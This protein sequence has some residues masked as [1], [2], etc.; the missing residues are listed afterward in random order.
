MSG[1]ALGY[2][3]GHAL[4]LCLGLGHG[5]Q[6]AL[7]HALRLCLGLGHGLQHALGHALRLCFGLGHGLQHA[8]GHA[9]RLC[10]GLGHGLQHALRHALRLC[11]VLGH[12]L[13][14]ALRRALRLCLGLGLVLGLSGGLG[15]V[16]A[17]H[18]VTDLALT[19]TA[20]EDQRLTIAGSGFDDGHSPA[21]TLVYEWARS[22][23]GDGDDFVVIAD[24]TERRYQLIQADVGRRVRGSVLYTNTDGTANSRVAG[25]SAPVA[26]VNDPTTGLPVITGDHIQGETLTADTSAIMDEDGLGTFTYRWLRNGQL[27]PVST[28][29]TYTL[30]QADVGAIMF[31]DVF[32]TDAQGTIQQTSLFSSFPRI[33]NIN[34]LPTGLA[35]SG[36]LLVGQTLRADT[37]A[38]VDIDGL[39]AESEFSYQWRADGADIA[40]A[41]EPEYLL[42][43][44]NIGAQ[45]SLNLQYRDA[46]E[47]D[48]SITSPAR[49]PVRGAGDNAAPTSGGLTVT[50][51]EDTDY[52]FAVAD[53]PF[54]DG[55]DDDSLQ[56]VRIDSL[57][58]PAS[59]GALT[60]NGA[61]LSAGQ[62]I[63][64]GAIAN[65]V[66]TPALNASGSV[67]FTYSVS[68]GVVFSTPSATATVTVTPVNDAPS[69]SGLAVTTDEDTPR[70]FGAADF[71]F[72]DGD[73]GDNLQAVRIDSLPTPASLGALTLNGAALSAGQEIAVGNIGTLVFTPALNASGD[74]SFTYSV[75]DGDEF[76]ATANAAITIAAVNDPPT[77][78]G[79]PQTRVSAGGTYNFTPGG[80]DVDDGDTLEYAISTLPEWADFDT[81][82]GA[83]TNK[84]NRPNSGDIRNYEDIVI[85]VTDGIIATPVTLPA[86]DIE[87]TAPN[88]PPTSIGSTVT[89]A[90]DSPYTFREADFP[91][92]DA[93][94]GDSLQAVRIVTLP[95]STSGNLALNGT[96]VIVGQVIAVGDIGTLMFTPVTNF[97]GTTTFLYSVSDGE[98]FS[99]ANRRVLVVVT[100]VNDPPDGEVMI[101]GTLRVG[102]TL[103][104]D[105]S[106]ISDADGPDSLEFTYQW[107]TH[108]GGTDTAISGADSATYTLST[109]DLGDQITVTVRYTDADTASQSLTSAPT[110]AV[111]ADLSGTTT[112][113]SV[114]P[115]GNP[116]VIFSDLSVS[117]RPD[118][119]RIRVL[120]PTALD[121]GDTTGLTADANTDEYSIFTR[122]GAE[123][124]A[125]PH[126]LF[127]AIAS[128]DAFTPARWHGL[129]RH[130]TFA[131]PAATGGRQIQLI[132]EVS[133]DS[134]S[135]YSS[136]TLTRTL[137]ISANNAPTSSGLMATLDEDDSHTFAAEQFGFA[138]T[139]SGDSLQAVRIDSLPA[140][141]NG[142]LAL[143]G[144]A[145]IVGQEIGVA[146]IPTLV[147]TPVANANGE[148][149]FTFSV[150]DGDD[151]ST[152]PATATL[153]VTPVDDAPTTSG[154]TATLDEDDSH[155]FAADQFGFDDA[156]SGDSLQQV[157]IDTLPAA[158]SGS[159]AL[160]GTPVTVPQEIG[161]AAIPTLVYTPVANVNGEATFTFSVSDGTAFSATATATLTVTPVNDAPTTSGLMANVTED[162]PHAFAAG[163]FNFVDADG[164]ALHSL[165]IDTLPA[166]GSLALS[167]TAVDA[168]DVIAAADIPNL[169]Y[170]PATNATGTVTFTYSLSDNTAFSAPP[171]TATLTI[172]AD[173]DAPTTTGLMVNVTEDTPHAFAAGQFNF[174]DADGDALH[175]L[176]IDTLPATGSLALS[177]TAVDA[178]DVIAAADIPNLVYTPATNATGT[179]TF[180]YSLSDNTAFSAPPATATLTITADNDAP[181]TTG[182]M[183]NV[184][185][186]TPHAFAAGQFNFVDA[187]GDALHSL[188]IDTLPATG[189]LAL[190]GTAVDAMDVIAAADIPNL[191]YTPATN[192]TGTVTFTYS[193]SDNTAFSAPP[194]TATLTITADNDAPTTTGLM[195]NVTEDTPHAFAAGQFNFVDA[196]GD[197]LHSLRIDT[198]P[199][200]GSLALSG[201]A[202]DAMDVIAAA[203]IPNLVYTP[204]TNATG[205]VTFTYS[206]SDNTAFSAPPAT[207]TLTITADN[208]APTTTGLMVNVTED[209]PH[210]FAA[211]QFNFVDA[212]GDALHSLRIDTL[213]ATGSLALSGTA[214]DAM[215]V[216]AAADIPNLVYTPATNATGTVTFTYSLSDNTAFSAPPATAT[217]TI[218][219]DNDAPTTTGLMV[220][221]TED[222]PHAFAAGQFNFV[223]ADG[224][225]LHSLRI[226]TLPATGSLA[227][228][229][230]AVDAMDVI[231]AAD[232]PNLVYTPATNATGT[233]TFT[234][235]LSDNT[236]F[237]APPATATLTI[238]A[239]N[240]APTTTGLMV[241]VTEDT[242]HAFAAGQFNFVDADGDALHSLRIDT[243]PAT[244]S[245]ALSGTAVD[246]MDVIA[247][248]DIPNLVY[249]PATNA[250]GTVTFT[251]SL[252]DNT[253]FS[254]PP[255]TATLTITADNDAPTTTGLMVNVTEDTPHAFA[256]GQFNFVDADGD[257][258]HSLRIDTLPATGSLALSGTAVD[259]M[260]VIAAADIP[261]LVYTPATN[262][263][264]TV[265]FT[266]SL[267]DNT[268][269]S[270]PP[271]TAT[272]TITEASVPAP[273]PGP[274]PGPSAPPPEVPDA[275]EAEAQG[276]EPASTN[277]AG[278]AITLPASEEVD[279]S[280]AS[281]A[282]FTVTSTL[283]G[284]TTDHDVTAIRAGSII[285]DVTPPIPAGAD[286]EVSY[287]PALGSITSTATGEELA[288]FM[289]L[290]VANTVPAQVAPVAN[291]GEPQTVA[292]GATVTLNGSAT[293]PD[294]DAADLSYAWTQTSGQQ[295]TLSGADSPS[296]SFTAPTGLS[297]DAVLVFSL[298]VSDGSLSAS[299]SVNVTVTNVNDAP[300][301]D[302]GENQSVDEGA[303]VT[304]SGSGTDP[305]TG[306]SLSYA[307]TQTS[308]QDVTLSGADSP[309]ASFTAPT[310]LGVDAVLGF[311]LTVS[312]GRLSASAS[313]TVTVTAA[314]KAPSADAGA[315][316]SVDEG[317]A[318]TLSGSGT[319]PDP[320]DT[321]SLS[322]AWIQ[323]GGPTVSLSRANSASPSFTAPNALD[324]DTVLTFRLTVTDPRGASGSDSVQVTVET[325]VAARQQALELNLA[326]FGRSV[327]AS[328]V[329]AIGERLKPASA[330]PQ[331]STVSGLSLAACLSSI[332]NLISADTV[333][334]NSDS[335]ADSKTTADNTTDSA[336]STV[337]TNTAS[338]N[339]VSANTAT[340]HTA[341]LGD[342]GSSGDLGSTGNLGDSM[343]GLNRASTDRQSYNP[344]GSACQL[345]DREQLA[346]SAF[347]IPLGLNQNLN[348]NLNENNS[349]AEPSAQWSLWGRGD[350]SHFEGSPQSDFD[351]DGEV[352]SGYLGLDYRL[353]T[354]A[355]VGVAL[356]HSS[357]ETDYRSGE[358]DGELETDLSSVYP[359]GYW[360]PRD[361]L[362]LWGL[363]GIG[364]GDATLSHGATTFET[365]LDMRLGALGLRQALHS[366]GEFELAL[367]ADAFIVELESEDVPGLPEV[368]AQARR[369]RLLLEASRHWQVQPE[370]SLS[371][372]LELGVRVDGGDAEEG[373]GA[374]VGVGLEYANGR[375][376][377]TALRAHGL[378]AHKESDFEAWGASLTVQLDPG[379]SGQG[380][381]L[382]LTPVWGQDSGGGAQALWESERAL[383]DSGLA[384]R[385]T[386][387]LELNLSY[388]LVQSD[389]LT[390]L[391]PFAQ[392]DMADGIARRLRLG[393]QLERPDG[394]ELEVFAGR[395]ASEQ[396]APEH[397][398]GLSGRLH[399]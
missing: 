138:D 300:S 22:S 260:D 362:G 128:G 118:V 159:L 254:A 5:L 359:Y 86:F 388:G 371:T 51:D 358:T 156:D 394:L 325:N 285:L 10:L 280:N 318:V 125:A 237:S 365:D 389:R 283:N 246:A 250:T 234:Y 24:A 28:E 244:G 279:V 26:N 216:I 289:S 79:S 91:F 361:G 137:T 238:T 170:T 356:S 273:G 225:A 126:N 239:D 193:L 284:V 40:N 61:A 142:S 347:V 256:A 286:I 390:R 64:S 367:K 387:R 50:T 298:T 290:S 218:T 383:Q 75:S 392:L 188:R 370:A 148:A 111:S 81:A 112:P 62:V 213:P 183:V 113:L 94:A 316:Q 375:G 287:R 233:V 377:S 396:R 151:F 90:E 42:T 311:S 66:F 160:N 210:A 197:A 116:V 206:L 380:L 310:E 257:A 130:V 143:D 393:M 312:D 391:R 117:G 99:V 309:S 265:T 56:A 144:T 45:I 266:Y 381:A 103:T 198:L 227:L 43:A 308:G 271:A 84:T 49:G 65:L 187:D 350:F 352:V 48:E 378:L 93:D 364:Q 119:F 292:E 268:A 332:T 134:G 63:A 360:S 139:D 92:N 276:L 179:V 2:A 80:G 231:A 363:L 327:A 71:P 314:N 321:E 77:I 202:V 315:D 199:A 261:N 11:F 240:D 219:A 7:H 46:F 162:T 25:I 150:S 73:T 33:T 376:L 291:A 340:V 262:A 341:G 203:D 157:R 293:D 385:P 97:N 83:L 161:V 399:F 214:V 141:G 168:M 34:D 172:T 274:A 242:P 269:F 12:G 54:D 217:L 140:A 100:A 68:D 372:S 129:L 181:T 36:G 35:I 243:L 221:V 384:Q 357:G 373:E 167:G 72:S 208:D 37:S 331:T 6:H 98:D 189:S 1:R 166:T 303:A 154:L 294:S 39:P 8:L 114:T 398:L 345:P 30:T 53:F 58:T 326:A 121:D 342:L 288:S 324:T 82:T 89:T 135:S 211:G 235:S 282:D 304:L 194:A 252:S 95:A 249:T 145:V 76:S 88:N 21:G 105:T 60:L 236:A 78:S 146:A 3:L 354:G 328:A 47:A 102:A 295:V 355:L 32:H 301:A 335:T 317:A 255:A 263:T 18:L 319:D 9:L 115:G 397:L 101:S 106:G 14:H 223:D 334:A 132:A 204:A 17:D 153:T 229:G 368:T 226:D 382:T 395:N 155:T 212:D 270:A 96:A 184:T 343:G 296:P 346:R 215:D 369:A 67:I 267:S 307:W 38:L 136:Q 230:T 123:A 165:R 110:A 379:V 205:T 275:D 23:D 15:A 330:G 264:G 174:V 277:P 297:A 127:T 158:G 259:A 348:Q 232:I 337:S 164:D 201:T 192:A 222:T 163:Q 333:T 74:V 180:T 120:N 109:G 152:T 178:M 329:D 344:V 19:G 85:S 272:L 69:S 245:L 220:N 41:T 185:E 302:A 305:D 336:D 13:Q 241:N 173:N 320:G 366:T 247:A 278:T 176:R 251:Y 182:L 209:T 299:D 27:P 313:V 107:N 122:T 171:A 258:L 323:T 224:D 131:A 87:V 31:L 44:A 20:R 191:V 195:V 248:A 147:Y 281:P 16:Y 190:S 386:A 59:L 353:E 55:D 338:A 175:S 29:R 177:G 149:N 322:Y 108:S 104:A 228:S 349:T 52:T 200:T 306:D 339:T 374:E 351:L 4:R 124:S 196:D 186:D 57:P 253:A 70:A 207:A 133:Y 169:V